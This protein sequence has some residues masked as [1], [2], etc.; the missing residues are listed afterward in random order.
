MTSST[1]NIT[2]EKANAL[3][4]PCKWGRIGCWRVSRYNN[5]SGL[6]RSCRECA[7]SRNRANRSRNASFYATGQTRKERLKLGLCYNCTRGAAVIGERLCS[8][9][10]ERSN[11]ANKRHNK[12]AK[13]VIFNFYGHKCV[14]CGEQEPK[15]LTI[16]HIN[17]NGK[18]DRGKGRATEW[19]LALARKIRQGNP[20]TDLRILCYNCN[21]GRQRNGGLCPHEQ[22]KQCLVA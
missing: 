3:N 15:F 9:C 14:C 2:M 12:A 6:S 10:K 17:N 13:E 1:K 8:V 22:K 7:R 18:E 20:P 21:C 16:D 5:G 11:E 19:Y 4:L